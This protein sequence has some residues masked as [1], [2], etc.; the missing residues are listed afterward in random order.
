[1]KAKGLVSALAIDTNNV[2]LIA[3]EK[4]TGEMLF[5]LSFEA[6]IEAEDT[7]IAVGEEPNLH[8]LARDLSPTD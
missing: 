2:F 1:M 7:L 8:A 4:S 5:N 3:I 6:V